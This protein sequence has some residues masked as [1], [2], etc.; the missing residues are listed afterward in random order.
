MP[1]VK[2]LLIA[3]ALIGLTQWSATASA[4]DKAQVVE[5]NY[6]G[7]PHWIHISHPEVK[8]PKTYLPIVVYPGDGVYIRADGCVQTGGRGRTWK[9]YVDP[10]GPNSDRLYHGQIQIPGAVE[11]LTD[12]DELIGSGGAWSR[13]FT[14][15]GVNS[16]PGRIAIG[17]SDDGYGDNGYYSHDDG[18]EG[19]CKSNI[20]AFLDIYIC[21]GDAAHG[22]KC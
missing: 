16:F 15:S 1:S 8:Q 12:L 3:T 18:T 9:R 21:R 2:R 6:L 11:A 7:D 4:D 22:A 19:Q 17:Y 10:S 5:F 14:I 13:F 20:D